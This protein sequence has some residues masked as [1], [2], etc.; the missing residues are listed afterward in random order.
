M[1]NTSFCTKIKEKRVALE[2][3][4][5]DLAEKL[6]VTPQA[7]SRW[8]SGDVEPSLGAIKEMASIFGCSVD[9]LLSDSEKDSAETNDTGEKE[10]EAAPV[11]QA[12]LPILAVC[13]K[14][15]APIYKQG[16][17]HT[18]TESHRVGRH[19]ETVSKIIC[20][21]CHQ[22][23]LK[24]EKIEEARKR[25]YERVAGV[26]R[27]KRSFI[28]PSIIVGVLFAIVLAIC[29]GNNASAGVTVGVSIG[30]W[31]L[32]PYI[33]CLFLNN[34]FLGEMSLEIW[35]WGF[36][37]MPGVI[38]SFSLDG[39]FW[40]LTVKLFLWILGFLIAAAAAALAIAVGTVCGIFVYPFAISRNFRE[41]QYTTL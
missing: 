4:Q 40:L 2:L 7:I 27:R 15:G 13:S 12:P 29:V 34:N 33:A 3:T 32:W 6:N 9:E 14:C 17:I 28:W 41:P 31:L 1:N 22:D 20:E 16:E 19:T 24:Q 23:R 8:E 18:Y 37:K 36:V 25:E 26:K 21:K 39:L 30:I 11:V 35:S 38:F 10:D 5:K